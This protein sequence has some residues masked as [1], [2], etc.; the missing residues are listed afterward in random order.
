MLVG[1]VTMYRRILVPLDGSP[2]AE[3]VLP[4]TKQL[5]TCGSS[6]VLLFRAIE[7]LHAKLRVEG[8]ILNVADQIELMRGTAVEYLETV[9]RDFAAAGIHA[10]RDV[11]VGLPAAAILHA[12]ETAPVDLIAMATHGRSGLQRWVYGSVTDKVLSSARLPVLLVRAGAVTPPGPITRILVPLDG[13]DLAER[14]LVPAVMMAKCLNAEL[15]LYRAWQAQMY[16]LSG[17]MAGSAAVA[18]EDDIR[19]AVQDYVQRMAVKVSEQGVR[20][21]WLAGYQTAAEGIL[22][23][24]QKERPGLIVMSTHGRSGVGRWVMGS[25]ADRVLRTSDVPVLLIRSGVAVEQAAAA[26]PH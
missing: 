16:A 14:A 2:I 4:L 5:A 17:M 6:S 26:Q 13:S 9:R 19:A 22:E 24:G 25:V 11:Q 15:L 18:L 8:E 20:V 21:R 12:A 7:P 23:T 10:D 1:E 3:Q